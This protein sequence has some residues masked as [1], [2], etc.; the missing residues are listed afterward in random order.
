M[1]LSI[2]IGIV[3]DGD[4]AASARGDA[5]LN[6][7]FDQC[8][9]EPVGVIAAIRQ[10]GSSLGQGRQQRP[11]ADVVAGLPGAQIQA[12]GPPLGIRDSVQL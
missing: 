10:E 2:E 8:V 7:A 11:G 6:I 1:A 5:G 3:G 4:L 9:A 12:D